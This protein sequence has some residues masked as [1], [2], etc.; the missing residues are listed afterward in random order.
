MSAYR[1]DTGR[2]VSDWPGE[3]WNWATH[4]KGRGHTVSAG[5]PHPLT[6]YH[7]PRSRHFDPWLLEA[8]NHSDS[9]HGQGRLPWISPQWPP[10]ADSLSETCRTRAAMP[11]DTQTQSKPASLLFAHAVS[12]DVCVVDTIAE[13]PKQPEAQ[14]K[15][16]GPAAQGVIA[17]RSPTADEQTRPA[18][19]SEF[20]FDPEDLDWDG[21]MSIDGESEELYQ[22]E[23]VSGSDVHEGPATQPELAA[24]STLSPNL[25]LWLP[26]SPIHVLPLGRRLDSRSNSY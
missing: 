17:R 16:L 19:I 2:R 14:R 13:T 9:G 11:E 18:S 4:Q 3:S 24:A 5:E 20:D 26:M 15:A 1:S 23:N 10:I 12:S 25:N 8:T 22:G 7:R 21:D 6:D